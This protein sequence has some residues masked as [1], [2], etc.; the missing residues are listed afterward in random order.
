MAQRINSGYGR[1]VKLI[2]E[3]GAILSFVLPTYV[4]DIIH[5]VFNVGETFSYFMP[6]F[7]I[8]SR[9]IYSSFW[10]NVDMI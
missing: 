10:I 1:M 2:S 6:T 5:D 4:A 9:D 3:E 7:N 8:E